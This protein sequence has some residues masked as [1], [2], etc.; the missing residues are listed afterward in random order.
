MHFHH[1]VH[2]LNCRTLSAKEPSCVG[3]FFWRMTYQDKAS[4]A[5]PLPCKKSPVASGSF[6][7]RDLRL[8]ASYESLHHEWRGPGG[9]HIMVGL[10][11]KK[12]SV[13]S[14]SFCGKRPTI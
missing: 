8:K 4:Y 2:T 7:E 5:F 14:G 12:S 6:A 13:V 1:P 11:P 10:F 3:L 9:C